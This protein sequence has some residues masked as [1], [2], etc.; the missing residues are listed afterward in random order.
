MKTKILDFEIERLK[1]LDRD[2]QLSDWGKKML[3]EFKEIKI[4]LPTPVVEGKIE[5]FTCECRVCGKLFGDKSSL[6]EHYNSK[7]Y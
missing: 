3:I 5:Q 1:L 7:H 4:L 2:G 6:N